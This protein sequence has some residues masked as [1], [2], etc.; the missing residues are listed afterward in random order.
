[1][2]RTQNNAS[3]YQLIT[4]LISKKTQITCEEVA[5]FPH[6]MSTCSTS[7]STEVFTLQHCYHF[8][9]KTSR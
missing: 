3:V 8:P 6:C 7:Q 4:V 1:M 9:F 5:T 2:E